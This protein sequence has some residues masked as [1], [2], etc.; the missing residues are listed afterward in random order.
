MRNVDHKVDVTALPFG[1]ESYDFVF[2]SHVLEHVR[3][4]EKAIREIRRVLRPQ[5]IAILPVPVVCEKT[6]EYPEANPHEAGHVR[7]PGTDYP[8]RY[9]KYFGRVEVHSSGNY[10]REFQVFTYEDR[11]RWPTSECPLRPPMQGAKH[12][13]F[14]PVCYT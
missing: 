3:E 12:P 5:G 4:D 13:D 6:I 10:A 1:D 14:V 11:T 2:A 7:A 9:R 8:E